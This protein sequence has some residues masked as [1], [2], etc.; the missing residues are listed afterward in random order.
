MSSRYCVGTRRVS[1]LDSSLV[2]T[3]SKL[4]DRTKELG[5]FETRMI[6]EVKLYFITYQ[7][8]LGHTD[9]TKTEQQLTNWKLEFT[10]LFSMW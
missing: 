4:Q 10:D 8:C 1:V 9:R 6:A 7:Q 3:C 5:N 2:A